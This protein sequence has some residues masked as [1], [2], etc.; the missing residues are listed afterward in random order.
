VADHIKLQILK[1]IT[2]DLN[3]VTVANGYEHDLAG[4][5]FRGRS[6]FS[7]TTDKPPIISIIEA[8]AAANTSFADVGGTVK[9]SD[10]TLLV[11]GWAADPSKGIIGADHP[12]DAVYA[13]L[14]DVQR[15]LSDY[16]LTN[17]KGQPVW[18]GKYMIY[19]L[20][21][22]VKL[23]APVVRPADNEVSSLAFFY[24]PV[25]I[26]LAYLLNEPWHVAN[27]SG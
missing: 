18:P 5:V 11:Q 14:A 24:L 8:P 4:R 20:A 21:S 2:E 3:N 19:N 17:K 12:T 25:R 26:D 16:V 9:E 6:A 13:L 10:W 1:R 7:A 23:G 27:K 22:A 15:R